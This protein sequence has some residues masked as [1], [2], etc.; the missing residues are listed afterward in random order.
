[1]ALLAI[2]GTVVGAGVVAGVVGLD[3]DRDVYRVG[4]DTDSPYADAV[5]A[6]PALTLVPAERATL[7]TNADLVVY[8]RGA[9]EGVVVRATD[10]PK[11]EAAAAEFREAVEAHNERLMAAES[12]RTAAFPLTVTLQY[13]SRSGPVT[14]DTTVGGDSTVGDGN[15][16]TKGDV[17]G[18]AGAGPDGAETGADGGADDG[19]G[20]T[21]E[22]GSDDGPGDDGSDDGPGDDGSGD[23]ATS[24]D[25]DADD[26]LSATTERVPMETGT[27]GTRRTAGSRFPRS[28]ARRS[29][30]EPSALRDPSRRRS[31]SPRS[32]W[33]SSS[34]SR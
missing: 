27:E 21:G 1:V 19:D 33:R 23:D 20:V 7:G 28:A 32:C 15:G 31:R 2:A 25:G 17:D 18:D 24:T 8:D 30:P 4:V 11:G 22:D 34:S 9:I 16:G 10:T 5:E 29:E 14:E 6:E 26:G 12:N 13:A 3:V